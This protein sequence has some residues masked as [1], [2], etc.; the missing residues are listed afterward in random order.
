M[1]VLREDQV[2]R[3]NR[4]G[5][6]WLWLI[7]IPPALVLL[8]LVPLVH[9]IT[10]QFGDRFLRVGVLWAAAPPRVPLVTASSGPFSFPAER[11]GFWQTGWLGGLRV[12]PCQYWVA[13]VREQKVQ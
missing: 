9:P 1:P 11:S 4:G 2:K 3:V 7:A 8:L 10:M 12:G 13:W 6:H 5:R